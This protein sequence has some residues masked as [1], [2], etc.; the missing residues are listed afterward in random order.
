MGCMPYYFRIDKPLTFGTGRTLENFT[1]IETF[2]GHNLHLIRVV[3]MPDA[4]EP[5]TAMPFLVEANRVDSDLPLPPR[6]GA[7]GKTAK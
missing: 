3:T 6:P 5:L 1:H 4:P 7:G 2:G